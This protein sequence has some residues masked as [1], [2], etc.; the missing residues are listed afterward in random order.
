MLQVDGDVFAAFIEEGNGHGARH[1]RKLISESAACPWEE[2]TGATIAVPA[3]IA[4]LAIFID[5]VLDWLVF[6]FGLGVENC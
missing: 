5:V 1:K 6:S 4:Q 2:S 3:I